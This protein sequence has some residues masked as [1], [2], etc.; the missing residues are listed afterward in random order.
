[1]RGGG[2]TVKIA[3]EKIKRKSVTWFSN[4]YTYKT[5][6]RILDYRQSG[7]NGAAMRILPIA[8]ANLGNV[9]KIK[10]GDFL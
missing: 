4:F 9:E 6:D 1:M 10:R 5:N 7:A 2:R 8:L 3:A